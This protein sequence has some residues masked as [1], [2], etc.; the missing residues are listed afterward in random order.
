MGFNI[1]KTIKTELH[2]KDIALIAIALGD[3]QKKYKD[4][5]SPE[6]LEQAKKLVERLTTEMCDYQQDEDC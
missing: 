3:Y 5:V 4:A 1:N 6:I 2:Y